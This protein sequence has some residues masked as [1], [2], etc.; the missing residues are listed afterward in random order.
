MIIFRVIQ[1]LKMVKKKAFEFLNSIIFIL[2]IDFFKTV[3]LYITNF[4]LNVLI[5]YILNIFNDNNNY[6]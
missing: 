6:L 1:F 5:N 2:L 4:M 3:I